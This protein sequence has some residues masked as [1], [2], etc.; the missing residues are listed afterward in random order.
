MLRCTDL[1]LET[2]YHPTCTIPS[3]YAESNCSKLGGSSV[4]QLLHM[5]ETTN[6]ATFLHSTLCSTTSM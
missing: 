6:L 4:R 3:M 5:H 2:V 1:P